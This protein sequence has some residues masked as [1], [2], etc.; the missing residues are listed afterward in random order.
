MGLAP[1]PTIGDSTLCTRTSKT[2]V[3][4]SMRENFDGIGVKPDCEKQ[5]IF[6]CV[7][8][9]KLYNENDIA[10]LAAVLKGVDITEVFSPERV[11]KLCVK[12]GLV[13]GDSFDLRDGYDLSDEKVQAMVVSRIRKSRPLLV[14]GSPPCTCF[15]RIQQ[16]NLHIQGPEWAERFAADNV[17]ATLHIEFCLKLF[18]IQRADGAYF[19]ISEQ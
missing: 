2:D 19:L 18:K 6:S 14:I 13:A 7:A 3:S 9:G 12:Y 1:E 4:N 16:F 5:Q 10:V 17:K 8:N 15:S 11:T